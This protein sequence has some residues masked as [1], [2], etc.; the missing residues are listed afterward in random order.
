MKLN[1]EIFLERSGQYKLKETAI[2]ISGN[3]VSFI[4]KIEN[5]IIKKFTKDVYSKKNIID[6]NINKNINL[7]DLTNSKSLFGNHNIIRIKNPNESLIKDLDSININNNTIIINGEGIKNNS[8]IKKYFDA[9]KNF[10]SI[11][12][13]KLTSQFKKKLV[14]K[15][16][17]QQKINLTSEAYWFLVEN[18]NDEYQ[19]LENDLEKIMNYNKENI[20]IKDLKE[21]SVNY[22]QVS[23]DDLFFQ[24]LTSK[25]DLILRR[26]SQAIRSSVDAYNFLQI[27]KNFTKI[28]TI[29]SE[30]KIERSINS[31]AN[32]YLP[33]YLFRQKENFK[34]II[35]NTDIYKITIINYLILKTELLLRKNDA[36][37]LII[38]Q[39]FLLNCAKTLK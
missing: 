10:Y 8:K 4:S 5:L 15:F 34:T 38:I 29:T 13:Y 23:L 21:L 31:L 25:N 14:D 39:R 26:T 32:S 22:N 28:L 36:N 16:V 6:L 2:L 37:F 3:A 20:T 17:N 27:I 24:C 11:V 7:K 35:S 12:C 18:L 19:L 9:H 33:K 30:Q 1:G